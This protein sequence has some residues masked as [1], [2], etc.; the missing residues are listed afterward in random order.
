MTASVRIFGIDGGSEC[1]HYVGQKFGLLTVKL[2]VAGIARLKWRQPRPASLLRMNQ[3]P[4]V[5]LYS[6]PP[7][8]QKRFTPS[9]SGTTMA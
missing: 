8:N 1:P 6:V 2:Q 9:V 3:I 7:A 4:L 5:D